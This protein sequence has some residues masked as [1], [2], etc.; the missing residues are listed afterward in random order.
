MKY[1]IFTPCEP[2]FLNVFATLC[3]LEGCSNLISEGHQITLVDCDGNIP[4]GC[5][6]NRSHNKWVC[7]NC[8]RYKKVLFK[9]LSKKIHIIPLSK[10]IH[11][12]A[13]DY[14]FSYETVDELKKCEYKDVEIGYC[15]L[16]TYISVSRNL[17]PLIDQSSKKFFD[18]FLRQACQ[19]TDMVNAVIE[20]TRPDVLGCFNCRFV[21]CRPVVNLAQKNKI[22]F[23]EFELWHR[24]N[25]N[26]SIAK[27]EN[28][29]VHDINHC[30]LLINKLWNDEIRIDE[31]TK[32]AEQFFYKRRNS[33]YSGYKL[34]VKDQ[35]LG[36]L[37]PQWNDREQNIVIFNSSEDE[38]SS[39]G[40]E[41]EKSKKENLFKT[42]YQGI[43]YIAE[44]YK[45]SKTIH[46]YL[47]VHPNLK[48]VHYSF[49]Q[50]LYELESIANNFTVISANSPISTYSLIDAADKVIVFGST[51]GVEATYWGKPVIL[52]SNCI[53][54]QL[55]FCY[56]PN[57]LEEMNDLILAPSLETKRNEGVLKYAYFIL[58]DYYPEFKI[59]RYRIKRIK[60]FNKIRELTLFDG[61]II[62]TLRT[63][64]IQIIGKWH[65]FP[66]FHDYPKAEDPN[67]V[68]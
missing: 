34:Y 35:V 25:G 16:S 49:H 5:C 62:K 8:R 56:C 64:I 52:L 58:N 11:S 57:N 59:Y 55:G 2:S 39:L 1:T 60:V 32:I 20:D 27:Y 10:Y 28:V 15:S 23:V 9:Q 68:L 7:H 47:R 42:Q 61:Q 30:L 43:K 50:K 12:I 51:T 33:I 65:L 40:K 17:N 18:I 37:P 26:V 13:A 54:K 41:Y 6:F 53:Y 21:Y 66:A 48:D 14:H 44:K 19:Y 46:F 63:I 45:D 24:K 4:F 67:A 29:E 38:F 31:K 22:E 36:T 3:V